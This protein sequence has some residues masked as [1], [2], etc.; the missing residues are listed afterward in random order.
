MLAR[1]CFIDG[2]LDGVIRLWCWDDPLGTREL[3]TGF[4][5]FDLLIGACID[6]SEIL[7][8]GHHRCHAV[9]AQASRMEGRWNEC[10]A[11]RVHLHQR[12]QVSG[13]AEIVGVFAPGQ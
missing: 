1:Q 6:E 3:H 12:R 2:A 4:K 11:E 13:V 7:D 10:G 8:V 5:N 9:I